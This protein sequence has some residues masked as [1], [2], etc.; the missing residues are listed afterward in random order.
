M[1]EPPKT[2]HEID[3]CHSL[4]LR[5]ATEPNE[6]SLRLIVEEAGVLPEEVVVKIGAT[7]ITGCH[8]VRP[9]DGSRV[10]GITWNSYVAYSLINES[11]TVRDE[12]QEFSGRLFRTYTKSHFLD[13]VSRAT[14]ACK[15][16]PGP[17]QH[18]EVI[19]ESH[20]IDVVSVE[21]P[22]VRE[23]RLP[24]HLQRRSSGSFVK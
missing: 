5:E 11:F 18:I 4:F 13:Y 8:P 19:C 1:T 12:S 14:I 2:W 22:Q 17:L 3:S 24:S 7:E 16:H 6:N 21:F 15:E 20:V 9:M 10:F 23:I